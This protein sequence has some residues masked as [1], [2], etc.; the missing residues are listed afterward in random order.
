M[1]E[2]RWDGTNLDFRTQVDV[3]RDTFWILV[4][5][6]MSIARSEA[7]LGPAWR[8]ANND[9]YGFGTYQDRKSSSTSGSASA[10][11]H[12]EPDSGL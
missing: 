12:T 2:E 10:G 11:G 8:L 5:F 9:F 7:T 3:V 4:A 1:G 6:L